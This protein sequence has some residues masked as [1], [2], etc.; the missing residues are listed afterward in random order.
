MPDNDEERQY[1][2]ADGVDRV[3]RPGL[4]LE[5]DDVIEGYPD[6]YEQHRDVLE[7]VEE[8]GDEPT[9]DTDTNTDTD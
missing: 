5:G 2:L 7:P 4:V 3:V 1:E 8:L 9:E 6:L